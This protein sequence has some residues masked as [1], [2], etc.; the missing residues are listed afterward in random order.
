[1]A[2]S[3]RPDLKAAAF[4]PALYQAIANQLSRLVD[5]GLERLGIIG[6]QRDSGGRFS[7]MSP[8]AQAMRF[9]SSARAT[10]LSGQRM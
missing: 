7:M 5:E 2:C 10:S 1:M 8:I 4:Y 3:E 6:C 9:S